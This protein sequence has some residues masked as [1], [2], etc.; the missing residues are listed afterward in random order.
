M[1]GGRPA[2]KPAPAFGKRMAAFRIAKGLSQQQL[3][4][5]LGLTRSRVNYYERAATN[6]SMEIVEK[7]AAFFGVTVGE[8]FNDSPRARQSPAHPRSSPAWSSA[9]NNCPAQSKRSSPR[10][11]KAS[12]GRP[13]EAARQRGRLGSRRRLG[14]AQG[15]RSEPGGSRRQARGVGGNEPAPA[16]EA[17]RPRGSGV[18]GAPR[19]PTRR[20]G[21]RGLAAQPQSGAE[22]LRRPRR[23]QAAPRPRAA[24]RGAE[25]ARLRPGGR[26]DPMGNRGLDRRP[27]P[28]GE[29]TVSRRW[30]PCGPHEAALARASR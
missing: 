13:H 23:R 30:G 3:A 24:P 17:Q 20:S 18:H 29:P 15:E 19:A 8:L 26:F 1:P 5:A 27:D 25:F 12:C 4:D 16:G 2:T 14:P 6:P 9:S 21:R 11:S 7:V 28:R 10:C 22:S